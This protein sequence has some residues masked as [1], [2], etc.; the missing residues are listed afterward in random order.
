MISLK[1]KLT[2]VQAQNSMNLCKNE[3]SWAAVAK[4]K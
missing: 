3:T 4:K 2:H 1:K